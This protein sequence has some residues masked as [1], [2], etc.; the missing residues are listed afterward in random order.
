LP[1]RILLSRRFLPIKRPDK[2][3]PQPGFASWNTPLIGKSAPGGAHARKLRWFVRF[4]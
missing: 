3:I 1:L 2:P 4:L